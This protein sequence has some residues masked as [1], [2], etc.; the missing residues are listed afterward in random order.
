M[1]APLPGIGGGFQVLSIF[2]LTGFF[3]VNPERATAASIMLWLMIC[4]PCVLLGLALLIYEGLSIKKLGAMAEK[5]RAAVE[6][7]A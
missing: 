5:G 1:L 2:V 6:G 3:Q 7:K 4:G